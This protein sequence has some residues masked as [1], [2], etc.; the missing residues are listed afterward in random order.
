MEYK[1]TLD[2]TSKIVT[3]IITILFLGNFAYTLTLFFEAKGDLTL[4][5]ANIFMIICFLLI[6]ALRYL[7]RPIKYRINNESIAI[8]RT[9]N[10]LIINIKDI[11]GTFATNKEQLPNFIGGGFWGYHGRSKTKSMGNMLFYATKRDNYVI[12]E[13]N[14]NKKIVLTPDNNAAMVKEIKRIMKK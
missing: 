10:D 11:R 6:Y 12:I 5:G 4:F 3:G 2:K 9:L 13:T 1:A 8:Q 14:D 7:Y